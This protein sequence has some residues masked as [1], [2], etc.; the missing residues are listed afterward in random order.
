MPGR[1]LGFVKTS[2]PSSLLNVPTKQ[3]DNSSRK[4]SRSQERRDSMDHVKRL[5]IGGRIHSSER[6]SSP[7]LEAKP[8][9]LDMV[10]ESP[11]LVFYNNP[12][13]STGALLSGQ[14]KLNVIEP[15]VVIEVF[16][17]QFIAKTTSR[18]PVSQHCEDC[19]KQDAEL[20]KWQFVTEPLGLAHGE[21]SFPF[22]YLIPGHLPATTHGSL[23]VLEYYLV[24]EARTATGEVIHF[25][26]PKALEIKRAII[27]GPEKHS[28]RIF[29]PTNLTA[30]VTLPPV[31]HPIGQFPVEMR[32]SGITTKQE[33][34][35]VRWRLRKLTWRIEEHQKWISPACSKHD[36]K[37]GGAGKGIFHEDTRVIADQ[38]V[39]HGWKT[40]F[41]DGSVE[42]EFQAAVNTSLKPVCDVDAENGLRVSHN[43]IIEMIVSE[44]WAPNKK[45]T[46]ATPTGAARVLRTQFHLCLTERSGLGISWDEE[47]PPMYEDVPA[48]PPTYT[49]VTDYDI[50]ELD[51][52]VDRLNLG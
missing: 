35:Q 50:R 19:A 48:S 4:A 2:P 5:S 38:E 30:Q 52:E 39:K 3:K 45:P 7:R 9:K 40:D 10:I 14:L 1:L 34:S 31:V 36:A 27:P 42:A 37:L 44:E 28:V 24:A 47:Q 8:A 43:F 32:L 15:A 29:P 25:E 11:P 21:H 49:Q 13:Q 26:K 20:K 6:K 12:A 23:A 46:Q 22:S 51:D 16:T 18:K 33:T 41:E 17:M